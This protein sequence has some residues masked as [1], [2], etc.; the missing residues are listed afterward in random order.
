VKNQHVKHSSNTELSDGIQS[1]A[2]DARYRSLFDYAPNGILIA[3]RNSYYLDANPSI[4]K[5]LGYSRTELIGMHASQIVSASETPHIQLALDEINSQNNHNREWQFKRKDGSFFTAEVIATEMPDGN[6]F[7][8]VR[9]LTA[10]KENEREI[11]RLSNLYAALSQVNQAIA[12]MPTQAELFDKIC[13]A[14]FEFGGFDMVWI[15]WHNPDTQ[16]IMPVAASG[17]DNYF[18]TNI[19][20]YGDDRPEG[21]GPIGSAF[22]TGKSYICNN[23]QNDPILLPWL[24]EIKRRNFHSSAAFPIRQN[25][26]VCGTLT[27][28]STA[29]YFFKNKEIALLEESAANISFALDN[30]MREEA[31]VQADRIAKNEKLFSDQMIESMPGILYFYDLKGKFLRWNRNFETASGYSADE[32]AQMHPLDFFAKEEQ[33]LLREKIAE[34]FE[35]GESSVKASFLS[36]DGK[37][38][39]YFFTGRKVIFNGVDCLV[40]MGLDVSEHEQAELKLVESEHKYRELVEHANSIILRWDSEG[41]ITF[42][43]EFGQRYFGYAQEEIIGLPLVGTIVPSADQDGRDM[44]TLMDNIRINPMAYEQNINQNIRKNGELVWIVWTNKFVCDELGKI[45]EILSIGSDITEQRQAEDTIRE[46]NTNLER[47]VVERTEELNTALVRAEAADRIKS[48]FLATMSHEL[49]TPLNSIIGFTGI[50][51]Q[52]L[53]G[54]LNPEQSKQ[55]GMVRGS[56]R[57]L[58][59]L[60]NDV[61]DISKIEAGQLEVK[62][63]RFNLTESIERAISLVKPMADKKGLVLESNIPHDLG[64]MVNDR[65]RLEQV[66]INLLNNAIKFTEQ[67]HVSLAVELIHDFSFP[68]TSRP[69]TVVCFRIKDTGIGIKPHDIQLLFQAFHQ[70]DTGLSRQHEGTG[71]GLAICRK[72]SALMGG[73]ISVRSEW[74]RG[75]EFTLI[76]PM[77]ISGGQL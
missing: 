32:I 63:E 27:V 20:I 2:V 25:G 57:H 41:K 12:R 67:G 39:T 35:K 4:C 59:E 48:A 33:Q 21:R 24:D 69:Q 5:M 19:K 77:D 53:A 52:G 61:L 54:P 71:L 8:I 73:D 44:Q 29:A 68:D 1:Q 72:L 76:L 14:L 36:K 38:T 11:T 13:H 62:P 17:D 26:Q 64:E 43:N 18:T 42:L 9:D 28:Y 46:L 7:G 66:L 60:I 22:R 75:S 74:L 47:R 45:V 65:R 30:L 58:L 31:R 34:V 49:R 23:M 6:L 16:Q 56:A 40:G 55:L 10:I 15:G 37:T 3:D 50:I 70:I 51:L